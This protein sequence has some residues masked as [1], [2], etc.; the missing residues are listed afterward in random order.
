MGV[1][2]QQT[3][4]FKNDNGFFEENTNQTKFRFTTLDNSSGNLFGSKMMPQLS[5]FR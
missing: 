5:P 2:T 1:G 3:N 4:H